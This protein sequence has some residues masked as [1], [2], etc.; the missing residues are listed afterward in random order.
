MQTRQYL[1][2][3]Y[4][5]AHKYKH[6]ADFDDLISATQFALY[7]AIITYQE[8]KSA[9]FMTYAC[10]C[11][12]NEIWMLLRKNRRRRP[13]TLYASMS[14]ITK[15]GQ[16][17]ELIPVCKY[18]TEPFWHLAIYLEQEVAKLSPFHRSLYEMTYIDGLTQAQIARKTGYTQSYICRILTKIKKQLR[19]DINL[20]VDT[21]AVCNDIV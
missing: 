10:K 20:G 17:F 5:F 7:K 15:D 3:A 6:C 19:D 11:I 13:E 18:S 8:D 2:L 1:D 21:I 12:N 14:N 4:K 16:E 9:N